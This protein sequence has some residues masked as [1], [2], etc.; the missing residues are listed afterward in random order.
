[1]CVLKRERKVQTKTK[2]NR[3]LS[4]TRT[5]NIPDV[6]CRTSNILV[7]LVSVTQG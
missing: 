2:P 7:S 5:R 3:K 6:F 4:G 1:M